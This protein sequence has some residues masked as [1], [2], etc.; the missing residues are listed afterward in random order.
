M[1]LI[2][3]MRRKISNPNFK[4]RYYSLDFNCFISILNIFLF[5]LFLQLFLSDIIDCIKWILFRPPRL[6]QTAR[7]LKCWIGVELRHKQKQNRLPHVRQLVIFCPKPHISLKR[8]PPWLM[9]N[10]V[11]FWHFG[12]FNLIFWRLPLSGTVVIKWKEF[13]V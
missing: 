7:G 8:S 6:T 13:E 11:L 4:N 10:D 3:Q 5:I 2:F 12:L 1:K 9:W